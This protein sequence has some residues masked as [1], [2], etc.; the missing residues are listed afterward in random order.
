MERRSAVPL[1]YLRSLP[2]AVVPLVVLAVA[3]GGLLAPPPVGGLLLLV[4]AAVLLWLA[5]LSWPALDRVGRGLRAVTVV[6]V[7]GVSLTRL[8]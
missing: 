4:L 8:T 5:Y 6:L 7:V 1:V 3:A 2:R